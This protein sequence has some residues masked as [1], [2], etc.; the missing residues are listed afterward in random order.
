[1]TF[2]IVIAED[3]PLTR[4]DLAEML[5]EMG[6]NVV[7]QARDGR[8]ALQLVERGDPDI[9]LLDVIMPGLDGIETARRLRH[10]HPVILIT[11]HTSPEFV[12]R[13]TDAGVMAYLGKPFRPQDLAPAIQL[14]VSNFLERAHLTQRL[15]KLSE[16][17]EA[18][19]TIEKAKGL[20]I[21]RDQLSEPEAYRRM[22]QLSMQ[23]NISL[24]QVAKAVI[25]MFT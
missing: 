10:R 18:R 16:Q 8:T 12:S 20:L 24:V 17:L 14:A 23:Q 5:T 1:M 13:A 19:K 4:R 22:Q 15:G 2:R 7:G 11:A 9:V 3:E 25:G 6:H 21:E